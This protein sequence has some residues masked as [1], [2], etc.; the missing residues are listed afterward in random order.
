MSLH[1]TS[2]TPDDQFFVDFGN[3]NKLQLEQLA[4]LNSY[5]FAFLATPDQ[6]SQFISQLEE[7][8]ATNS[9]PSNGLKNITKSL[10]NFFKVSLKRNLSANHV[11]D[12]L[13]QLGLSEDKAVHISQQWKSQMAAISRVAAGQTLM[14][15]QL[16]DMEWRFGVTAADSDMKKVGNSYL[17]L[18]LVVDKGEKTEDIFMELTLPQFYLFLHE[19]ERA[20][21]SLEYLS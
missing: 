12:D 13:I 17:Q 1:F 7:F 9:L 2:E 10:L 4:L 21:S 8:A 3:L 19:M 11:K 6:A 16:V 20:K 18:K 15:N 5:V 14:V